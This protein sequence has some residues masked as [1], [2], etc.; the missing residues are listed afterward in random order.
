MSRQKELDADPEK[1]KQTEFFGQLKNDNNQ[2]FANETIF[3]YINNFR[4]NQK[5]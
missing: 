2:I 4:K 5:N 1:I 3:F